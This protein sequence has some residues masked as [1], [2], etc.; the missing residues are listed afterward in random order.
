MEC[1]EWVGPPPSPLP[2]SFGCIGNCSSGSS[3]V[4]NSTTRQQN[5]VESKRC[6]QEMCRNH[7]FFFSFFFPP[8]RTAILAEANKHSASSATTGPPTTSSRH[9][10]TVPTPHIPHPMGKGMGREQLPVLAAVWWVDVERGQLAAVPPPAPSRFISSPLGSQPRGKKKKL[11][12]PQKK[13]KIGSGT[14]LH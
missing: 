7:L 11:F 13:K 14:L 2:C 3:Q 5:L 10:P 6:S 9:L 8:L 4:P 12:Y 1:S